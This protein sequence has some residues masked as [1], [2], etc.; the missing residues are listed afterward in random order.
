L[1]N[2]IVVKPVTSQD[3]LKKLKRTVG[4]LTGYKPTISV[5]QCYRV[6]ILMRLPRPFQ[7]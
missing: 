7:Q 5:F 4:A 1:K 2:H 3:T 6:W